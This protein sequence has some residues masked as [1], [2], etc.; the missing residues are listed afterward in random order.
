MAKR[1]MDEL[2][3]DITKSYHDLYSFDSKKVRYLGVVKDLVVTLAQLPMK[4]MVMDVVVGDIP[5][6]FGMLLSRSWLNKLG[7]SLQLDMSYAI[8]HVFGGEY[9]RLCREI[10]LAYIVSDH[11]NPTNH[12]IYAVKQ[13][14]GLSI[15]HTT[16]HE[17]GCL[18]VMN[19]SDIK[20]KNVKSEPKD[21]I[22]KMFFD[23]S[24]SKEGLGVRVV[25]FSLTNQVISLSYKLEFDITNNI[26]EYE[27]LILGLKVAKYLKVEHIEVFDESELIIQ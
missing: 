22:W 6:R 9:R 4:G 23:G 18:P 19:P 27:A 14:M 11:E 3:L 24:S 10:Q 7:G 16:T 15:L 13:D 21:Q 20:Q 17:T 12:P 1:V 5:P 8:V 2:G 26:V 25:L